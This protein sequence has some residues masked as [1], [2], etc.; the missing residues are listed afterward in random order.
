MLAFVNFLR[1]KQQKIFPH[2]KIRTRRAFSAEIFSLSNI[3][4][5]RY[6]NKRPSLKLFS[7]TTLREIREIF[8]DFA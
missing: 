2:P 5:N 6:K 3:F 8:K 7:T 4:E 1:S